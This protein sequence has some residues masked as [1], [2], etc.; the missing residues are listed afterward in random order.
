MGGKGPAPKER[1]T[2]ER[3][4]VKRVTLSADG[5]KRGFALPQL[6]V[7]D[8][9]TMATKVIPWHPRTVA[10]WN[11]W[12]E[13]PQAVRMLTEP[14]WDFLLETARL[15]HQFW[16]G[17]MSVAGELRLR[18]AKFGATPEDRLRLQLEIATPAQLTGGKTTGGATIT[19]LADRRARLANS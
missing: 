4:T 5:L 8:P 19:T 7:I 3:D 9:E 14:D 13:S 16:S 12:R 1:R 17:D 11:H 6:R 2:R 18:V 10:W 15:H